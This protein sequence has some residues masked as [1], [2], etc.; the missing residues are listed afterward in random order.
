MGARAK[1]G[2]CSHAPWLWIPSQVP[3]PVNLPVQ[4]TAGEADLTWT[5]CSGPAPSFPSFGCRL[6]AGILVTAGTI[7]LGTR[8]DI[9]GADFNFHLLRGL[10]INSVGKYPPSNYDK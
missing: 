1:A 5:Q 6:G 7:P 2:K 10:L 9:K 8:E 4:R 3:T